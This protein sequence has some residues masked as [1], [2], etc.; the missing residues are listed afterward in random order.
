MY[1]NGKKKE[2]KLKSELLK[3]NIV[4]ID[5]NIV[6]V[7]YFMYIYMYTVHTYTHTHQ[8]DFPVVFCEEETTFTHLGGA[9]DGNWA[10][11][12]LR[13]GCERRNKEA[14]KK[15]KGKKKIEKCG[16]SSPAAH[17]FAYCLATH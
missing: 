16:R 3:N 9:G 10:N 12:N 11:R 2:I 4:N 8:E 7:I 1:I 17:W 15:R 5:T 6:F 14:L 13:S